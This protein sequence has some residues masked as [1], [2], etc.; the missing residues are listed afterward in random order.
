MRSSLPTKNLVG[1]WRTL[2]SEPSTVRCS[3][4]Q[5]IQG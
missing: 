5:D 4:G 2:A 3:F 1:A